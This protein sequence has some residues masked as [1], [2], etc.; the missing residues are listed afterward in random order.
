[1]ELSYKTDLIEILDK[2]LEYHDIDSIKNAL[3]SKG[4]KRAVKGNSYLNIATIVYSTKRNHN[5]KLGW[6]ISEIA[7]RYNLSEKTV[8]RHIEKFRKELK[9][10]VGGKDINDVIDGYISFIYE[11]RPDMAQFPHLLPH[12]DCESFLRTYL[13][14]RHNVGEELF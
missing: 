3:N 4:R 1:M 9:E 8:N 7:E 2:L 11:I 5:S 12:K 14:V 6:A 10:L 13:I